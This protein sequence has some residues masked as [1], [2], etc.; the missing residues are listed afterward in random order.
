MAKFHGTIGYIRTEETAP[1]VFTEVVTERAYTGDIIRN[2][3]RFE[4]GQ[5]MNETLTVNNRFS[6][7]ADEFAFGNYPTMRYISWNGVKWE[8]MSF[9]VDHPRIIITVGGIYNG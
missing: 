6:V 9:E 8:I 2:S 3:R 4:G 7:I 5:N 1:G